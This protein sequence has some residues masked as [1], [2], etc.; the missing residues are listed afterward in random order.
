MP[1]RVPGS[2][3]SE[4]KPFESG[5]IEIMSEEC[6]FYSPLWDMDRVVATREYQAHSS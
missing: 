6:Q 4:E 1:I 5:I 3:Q 2:S